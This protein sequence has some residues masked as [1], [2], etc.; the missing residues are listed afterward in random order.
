MLQSERRGRRRPERRPNGI[1]GRR[2]CGPRLRGDLGRALPRKLEGLSHRRRR[3]RGGRGPVTPRRQRRPLDVRTRGSRFPRRTQPD[4]ARWRLLLAEQGGAIRRRAVHRRTR[5]EAPRH[6][7]RHLRLCGGIH[8]QHHH[9]A[10]GHLSADRAES[11][12][13]AARSPGRVRA[14]RCLGRRPVRVPRPRATATET[15]PFPAATSRR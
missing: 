14:H 15:T 9:A 13:H 5:H 11:A 12:G 7:R 6:P 8:R 10:S 3:A 2:Q 4:T 1:R